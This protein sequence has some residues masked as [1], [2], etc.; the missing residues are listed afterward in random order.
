MKTFDVNEDIKDLRE[1]LINA[2]WG[3]L[4][5][6]INERNQAVCELHALGLGVRNITSVE[7][8]P[9][10]KDVS[11][12]LAIMVDDS[13]EM[14]NKRVLSKATLRDIL[15]DWGGVQVRYKGFRV[16]PY[17]EDDWLKIDE[18]R[19]LRRAKPKNELF[20]F[21]QTLKGVNPA[22]A[23]LS[24]LSMK[25]YLG[26]IEIGDKAIGFEMKASR[27]GFLASIQVDQ[28]KIFTRFAIDWSTILRD[29]YLRE[30]FIIESK[31]SKADF[32]ATLGKEVE[33]SAVVETAVDYLESEVKTISRTLPTEDRKVLEKSFFRA[34]DAI[35]RQTSA[36]HSE[37]S[38]LRLIASTSTLLLIFYEG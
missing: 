19:G 1:Q 5:A 16:Y 17:G 36:D 30:R 25:N 24:M 26:N 29:Y 37:L 11:L 8:F 15:N 38:H 13:K 23:M 9:H 6:Y 34:T 2:G 7:T 28:L 4:T 20:A 35:R 18:E 31:K 14:R 12:E 10:L 33:T 21:A 3:T 22:R 27:E 32:E